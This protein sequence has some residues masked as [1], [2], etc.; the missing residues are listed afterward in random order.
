M[1]R[2]W[3]RFKV[4]QKTTPDINKRR[5]AFRGATRRVQMDSLR[6]EAK[7]IRKEGEGARLSAAGQEKYVKRTKKL[8]ERTEKHIKDFEDIYKK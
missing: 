8:T 2:W 1:S 4:K 5:A 3:K 6:K 7:A